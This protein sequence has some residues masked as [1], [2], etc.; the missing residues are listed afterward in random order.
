MAIRE[1]P[2]TL[3]ELERF[4]VEYERERFVYAETNRR[5]AYAA[6][7]MFL[8]W[9]PGVPK[10]LG[11]LGIAAIMDERLRRALAFPEPPRALVRTVELALRA[12]GRLARALPPRRRPKLRTALRHRTYPEGWRLEELG[13]TPRDAA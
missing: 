1:I 10:R 4:S 11:T 2:K 12:R 13:T 7:D 8:A 9:F 5:V 3:A 6:R